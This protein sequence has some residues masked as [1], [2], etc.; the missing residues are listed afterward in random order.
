MLYD[1]N[2]VWTPQTSAADLDRTLKFSAS[3]GYN[4][5]AL[6]HTFGTPIP[7]QIVN[8]IPQLTPPPKNF[9]QPP[10]SS[11]TTQN[12]SSSSSS[13]TPAAQP[14]SSKLPTTL[15]RATV[16][17]S[18]PATNHRLPQL[19]AA[20]DILALRPTTDVAFKA[21]CLSMTEHSII[22]L[23]LT[24]HFNFH[25]RPKPCMAAVNR[26]LRFEVCYGQLLTNTDARARAVFIAN[27]ISLVRATKGRGI[28]VSSE[29][30]GVLGLRAPA[31]VV[32]LLAVWGLGNERGVEALGT[33][34]RAVVM[35]EGIK[36]RGFRGVVDI[37]DQE[38]TI[39]GEEGVDGDDDDAESKTGKGKKGQQK[40]GK[41]GVGQ[42]QNA[43]QGANKGK[44]KHDGGSEAGAGEQT[45]PVMSKRQAKKLKF[46]ERKADVAPETPT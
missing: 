10:P 37:V 1:L 44:R 43:Q 31:D 39:P 14:P 45:P 35:N 11:T 12:A 40:G 25:F 20:Y 38:G 13:S 32:N 23:D 8:P 41:Q 34:P 42:K 3:L 22:S 19:A 29:A 33:N 6:N 15:R 24:T 5:V 21:A 18:D 30:R 16:L 26:G 36:R 28:V 2:I 7:S 4:V 46:A 17:L 9:P 27:T